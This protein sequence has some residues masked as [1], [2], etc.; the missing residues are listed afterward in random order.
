MENAS[1]ALLMAASVLIGVLLM[2]LM[3]YIFYFS[4]S[5]TGKIE[6]NMQAKNNYEFN[7]RFQVY[8]R[9]DDLTPQDILTI[10][11]LVKDINQKYE[12]GNTHI[13]ITG[14][15]THIDLQKHIDEEECTCTYKCT[16]KEYKNG[17]ISEISI[18]KN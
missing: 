14:T 2:S 12:D 3:V 15:T 16:I 8:D 18:N 7:V 1:K 6:E 17:K 13:E 10:I 11:N 5:Y 4:S 9:R